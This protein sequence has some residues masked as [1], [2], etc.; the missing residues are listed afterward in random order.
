[1][2]KSVESELGWARRQVLAKK[3]ARPPYRPVPLMSGLT[4]EDVEKP[5]EE[6]LAD[7]RLGNALVEKSDKLDKIL[8]NTEETVKLTRKIY[9]RLANRKKEVNIE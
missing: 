1:M 6:E 5:S 8:K 3:N 7:E 9:V 4:E 2:R